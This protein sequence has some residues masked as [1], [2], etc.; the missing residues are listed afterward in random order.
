LID[1]LKPGGRLISYGVLDDSAFALKASRILY[2]NMIW[3][4]F[5]ISG[6]LDTVS[7]SQLEKAQQE[8]WETLSASPDLMPVI[9][10]FELSRYQEAIRLTRGRPGPGK[11]LL[12]N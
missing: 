5:G 4:G 3:Q 1:A 2:K 8:L 12:V 7:Q 11:V 10:S 9:G 6:W